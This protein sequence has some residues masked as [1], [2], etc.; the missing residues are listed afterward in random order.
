MY[1]PGKT[2]K[3]LK[4]SF[5][6]QFNL[7]KTMGNNC[8]NR[9]SHFLSKIFANIAKVPAFNHTCF[10]IKYIQV[11]VGKTNNISDARI[12][13]MLYRAFIQI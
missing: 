4:I 13:E 6:H 7:W 12:C 8:T 9:D 5:Y 10:A 1:F 2:D 3:H 11:Q